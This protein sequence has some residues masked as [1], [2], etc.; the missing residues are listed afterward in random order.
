[1]SALVHQAALSLPESLLPLLAKLLESSGAKTE[2]EKTIRGWLAGGLPTALPADWEQDL[3]I[4]VENG[5]QIFR[6][7]KAA[8]ERFFFLPEES[9]TIPAGERLVSRTLLDHF[10]GSETWMVDDTVR[11]ILEKFEHFMDRFRR[12]YQP[13]LFGRLSVDISKIP[14]YLVLVARNETRKMDLRHPLHRVAGNLALC[15]LPDRTPEPRQSACDN[16]RRQAWRLARFWKKQG[17]SR[18]QRLEGWA[19]FL[20]WIPL[21]KSGRMQRRCIRL[22]ASRVAEKEPPLQ[23][24]GERI[25]RLLAQREDLEE[26]LLFA[27]AD[28]E[29]RQI[30][31]D[32][33]KI[34]IRLGRLREK[35]LAWRE[36][37]LPRPSDVDELLGSHVSNSY[38]ARFHRVSK[39]IEI[40]RARVQQQ[41]AEFRT[42]QAPQ[43]GLLVDK[44]TRHLAS[45]PKRKNNVSDRERWVILRADWLRQGFEILRETRSL[46]RYFRAMYDPGPTLL[47]KFLTDV[48]V[49]YHAGLLERRG[50]GGVLQDLTGWR[51]EH[52]LR[53]HATV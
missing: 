45:E 47:Q 37:F 39:E 21:R 38:M 2:E 51:L 30:E 7:F 33:D 9:Q 31:R 3:L 18:T 5:L 11:L 43:V 26:R 14:G 29:R 19:S 15:D 16:L 20:L 27:M 40:F 13:T 36:S 22:L 8:F 32:A 12:K 44:I 28:K 49:Y 35:E 34:R 50:I 10:G 24:L 53:I 52:V 42:D 4:A 48:E 23:K 17:F 1:M 46:A 6:N 25:S 41:M